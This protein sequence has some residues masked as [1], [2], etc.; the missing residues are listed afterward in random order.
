VAA[1]KR[2]GLHHVVITSV[3][4]DDLSDG[5]SSQFA[6][7]I[8]AL[9]KSD[10]GITIEVLVPDFAG[11]ASALQTV[12]DS[13]PNVINHNIET[14]PRLYPEVCPDADY[15]RSIELLKR[16]K[17]TSK[18][19]VTKSGL[20]LGLGESQA[21]VIEVM[22]DLHQANCDCLTIGQYL[23]PSSKHHPVLQF[24]TPSEFRKYVDIGK[25]MGFRH[26]VS[27]PLVRSSFCAAE[28]Y[29]LSR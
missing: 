12:I 15:Q 22:A 13:L 28:T 23:Q 6:Q 25:K 2:L 16:T 10:S 3:T 1:V 24:V 11:S 26:V 17:D 27:A 7:T 5:G 14:V 21:D 18:K 19:I 4:R 8:K 29:L 20:M 9:Q